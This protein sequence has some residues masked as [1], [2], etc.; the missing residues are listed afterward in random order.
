VYRFGE[1]TLD[2]SRFELRRG[3][4][5]LA[6]QPKIL[7]LLTHLVRHRDRVVTR[8][9]LFAEVWPGVRVGQA[10]LNRAV[11]ELRRVLGDDDTAPRF[12]ATIPRRGYRFVAP[13]EHAQALPTPAE[14]E[15]KMQ[16]ALVRA[17]AAGSFTELRAAF[18]AAGEIVHS[19]GS[20]LCMY[21]TEPGVTLTG[22]QADFIARHRPEYLRDDVPYTRAVT[23]FDYDTGPHAA[24][25][26]PSEALRQHYASTAYNE[27]YAPLKLNDFLCV[28]LT[29]GKT[30]APGCVVLLLARNVA[31]DDEEVRALAWLRDIFAASVDRVRRAEQDGALLGSALFDPTG[32]ARFSAWD[33]S[34]QLLWH[35]ARGAALLGAPKE[36]PDPLRAALSAWSDAA[37]GK[38]WEVA[39]P[40]AVAFVNEHNEPVLALIQLSRLPSSQPVLLV[41]F[42][43]RPRDAIIDRS[44][45]DQRMITERART[46]R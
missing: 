21:S 34:G 35:S 3:D 42:E 46:P 24:M 41:D 38:L 19:T 14:R 26:M 10:S 40:P 2:L 12:I 45:G 4:R 30:G 16:T 32:H 29:P 9:E 39:P 17:S 25:R 33:V 8:A 6:L 13:V 15:H 43:A 44:V 20:V 1:L 37:R 23:L 7:D 31:F 22:S 28:Q 18:D 5:A 11:R 36:L 27:F